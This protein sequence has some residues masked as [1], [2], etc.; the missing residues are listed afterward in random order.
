MLGIAIAGSQ[1][2]VGTLNLG[3]LGYTVKNRFANKKTNVTLKPRL[4]VHLDHLT[5]TFSLEALIH[6][7][8][9]TVQNC[10]CQN[11]VKFP[12]VLI[13][14][15]RNMAKRLKLCQMHSISTS[16]NLRHHTTVLNADV[17]NC[18]TNAESCYPQ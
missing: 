2:A 5:D 10:F 6:R 8:S 12:P 9:T 1:R 7:V 4:C 15:G 18:Y 11:F 13:I 3:N 17:R 16:T 14:F